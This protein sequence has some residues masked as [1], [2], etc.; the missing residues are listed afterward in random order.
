[1]RRGGKKDSIGNVAPAKA[2]KGNVKSKEGKFW[3][4][5]LDMVES[6]TGKIIS[7]NMVEKHEIGNS[8]TSFNEDNVLYSKLRPYLNK[9]VNPESS[10]YATS[11]LI[12][13][14]PNKQ[15]LNKV[16]LTQLLRSDFF[17]NYIQ[18]K[19]AGAEM[20]RV[21]MDIF[22]AFKVILPHLTLQNE[23]AT[24]IESIETQKALI[25]QSIGDVQQLFDYTMD[26]Y[27][28]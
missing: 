24:K 17:V 10:G 21:S 3:L 7:I 1:M 6:N 16:F 8:T 15:V 26:K 25:N 2:Y 13:L 9:V 22:R 4:L 12:P 11:E 20:P 19:V 14:L 5:N 23:F 18:E 28:N 27:F